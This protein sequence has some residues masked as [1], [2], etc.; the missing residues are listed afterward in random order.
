MLSAPSLIEDLESTMRQGSAAQR[1]SMLR[2]VTDLFLQHAPLCNEEQVALFDEVMLRLVK[3]IEQRALVQLSTQLAPVR[4]A[5]A[6]VIHVL[7]HDD[8]IEISRPVIQE[9][10]VLTDD[11]LVEIARSKSQEHLAAIAGRTHVAEKVTDVLVERGNA[12]VTLR[13]TR[14]SG[15]RFSRHALMQVATRANSDADLAETMVRRQD[16]P[17]DVFEHLLSKATEVVR[18]RL[19]KDADAETRGRINQILADIAEQVGRAEADAAP[20]VGG[21]GGT[22]TPKAAVRLKLQ[23]GDLARAGKRSETVAVLSALSKLPTAA[24]QSLLRAE[25]EDA[26]LIL[27]KAI[28]FEW[29]DAKSI[30]AVMTGHLAQDAEK[31]AFKKYYSMSE[32]TAHRVINFVK[33]CKAVSKADLQRML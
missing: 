4:N 3:R 12:T 20:A 17:P 6:K 30:L 26:V 24:L 29:T 5:P 32:E 13:V 33:A 21:V 27:C 25:A 2:R 23:V 10:P 14:N 7:A 9:S 22:P 19:L 8:D 18:Q 16:V 31:M 28:G 11:A 1:A 15:A